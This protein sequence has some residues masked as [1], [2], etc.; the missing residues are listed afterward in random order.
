MF[1][2]GASELLLLGIIVLI[3]IGPKELPTVA[4]AIGRFL[5]EV[6]RGSDAF[7]SELKFDSVQKSLTEEA[8]K[9]TKSIR[10]GVT[11][12]EHP[13]AKDSDP[14]LDSKKDPT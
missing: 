6:K 14:S 13:S 7:K 10:D 1:G 9:A 2:L 12:F 11:Q 3:F 8:L 5:N 4:R